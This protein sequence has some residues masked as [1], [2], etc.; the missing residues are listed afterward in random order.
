MK[1]IQE[2]PIPPPVQKTCKKCSTVVEVEEV[3]WETDCFKVSGY[4]FDGTAVSKD[5]RYVY[6]PYCKKEIFEK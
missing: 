6:C 5:L 4:H 3:D 2:P 1:I